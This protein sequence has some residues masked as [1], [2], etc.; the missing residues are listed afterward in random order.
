MF[1][2]LTGP[3]R[4][5]RPLFTQMS[6]EPFLYLCCTLKGNIDQTQT[7]FQ[8]SIEGYSKCSLGPKMPNKQSNYTITH[9]LA[10]TYMITLEDA[11]PC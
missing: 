11:V 9:L 5:V 10:D 1:I 7:Q 8:I 6:R 3:A 4:H 2:L